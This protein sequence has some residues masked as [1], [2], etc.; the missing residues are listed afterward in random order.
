MKQFR[1]MLLVL[2]SL[3]LGMTAFAGCA[4]PA[5]TAPAE[6]EATQ[7]QPVE[8]TAAVVE[9]TTV[10]P[11][12]GEITFITNRTDLAADGTYDEL[13]A[14]FKEKNP[15]A[16]INVESITD[17]S[18]EMATRMQ[19]EEYGDVLMI[20]DAVPSTE[21]AN[22]FEP[23]GTVEELSSKYQE[24]YLYA[25]WIDGQVY[26]LAYMC[27]VQ[28]IV[29][30]KQ[31]W[32]SAGITELPKTP[33]EFLADLQL[34]KDNTD[35]TPY[36][37]NAN[38]GWPLDQWQD[39]CFGS[40][41]GN[42]D[43]HNNEMPHDTNAWAEGS[44]HYTVAKLLYDIVANGLCEADPTTCDWEASKVALCK[45][46]IATMVLGNWAINQVKEMGAAAGGDPS[47]VGYMPFPVTDANG[48]Q[49][50][51]SGADYCYAVNIHSEN[52]DLAKAWV[53]FL[54][55]ESG[56]AASQG[57]ISLLKSDPMPAGLENFE[58]VAFIVDKPATEENMGKLS[59]VE[60]ESG[61]TLYDNGVRMNRIVDAARGASSET[62]E[63]IMADLNKLWADAIAAV[64]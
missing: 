36:Y 30:N 4:A 5:T 19:T 23:W 49:F 59:E 40:V 17:Y 61:I 53:T 50:A 52:K 64:G 1:R 37:T 15:D 48:K 13:I 33:D 42:A 7:E 58:G 34:I 28:G 55:D 39:H 44:S 46:E 47:Q 51:T 3:L 25:K 63:S 43:Y 45:G 38:S 56:L 9:E 16:V 57:G 35:A 29:Y 21:F 31:V 26:G 32:E 22:Y 20:P 27:T 6:V 2:V 11:L 24:G 54:L 14:K 60:I 12:S 8:E 62:F 10:A 41:T 18:G